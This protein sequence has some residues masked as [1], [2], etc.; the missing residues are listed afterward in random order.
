MLQADGSPARFVAELVSELPLPS[1][2]RNRTTPVPAGDSNAIQTCCEAVSVA[3]GTFT[4][5]QAAATGA[6][7]VP[8]VSRVPGWPPASE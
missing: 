1:P 8:W 7:I 5:F 2:S 3:D 6:V 4:T